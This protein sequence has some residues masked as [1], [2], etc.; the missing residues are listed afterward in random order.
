MQIT[1]RDAFQKAFAHEGAGRRAAARAIY[2]EILAALPG[3]PGALLKLADQ[4]IDGGMLD[5]AR[6]RL[7]AAIAGA[8]T[9]QLPAADIWFAYARL[10][11]KQGDRNAAREAC[12]RALEIAPDALGPLR[13]LA[14]LMLQEGDP[15]SAQALCRRA[16]QREPRDVESLHLLGKALKAMGAF[17]AARSVLIDCASIAGD[18]PEVLTTL[19][20]VCLDAGDAAEA[21]E[22]LE[23]AIAAGAQ[24]AGVWD[25]LGLAYRTRGDHEGALSAFERAVAADPELTPALA[26]LVHARRYL[27]EW[28]GLAKHEQRLIA[29]LDVPGSDPRWS[30]HIALNCS[31]TPAQELA[32][33]RRWSRAV[34]PTPATPR[35]AKPR[36]RRLRVGYLSSDFREH[37]TGRLMAGLFEQCDRSRLEIFA[38]SYG[39]DDGSELRS[40][41]RASFGSA[42]RDVQGASDAEAA[43][44]ICD[45]GLDVLIDRKGHTHGGRLAILASRPAPVQLHYMSFPGTL[46]YDAVD[47]LIAD[48]VVVPVGAEVDY[49]E[50]VWRMPRCYFVNDGH[51]ALP[52]SATRA[53]V[54][55]PEKVV[56][57]A[58]LNQS[59]KLS[60]PV[61]AA[62][63][64]GLRQAP[65][66]VLWLLAAGARAHANLRAH[67]AQAGVD[68]GRMLFA[69]PLAQDAHIARLRCAD[70]AL[71]TRPV[72]SHTT[73]CD[74]LWAGVPMLTCPGRTFAS[75]V[76]AS[77]LRA[78]GLPELIAASLDDY[79]ARLVE[80]ASAPDALRDYRAFL[81]RTRQHN[82]LFDT[83][84]FA[85]DWEALLERAYEGTLA[86]R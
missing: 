37:P 61:F 45:D 44:I 39:P 3:H 19:G 18:D 8:A 86:A 30:P 21:R 79:Q 77:V 81:E 10:H 38:Y 9:Q 62:W 27:C 56:V 23:Q 14:W 70:L 16:L 40:R 75:R 68:P 12:E 13:L 7:D 51:R 15:R 43:R 22:R 71:D 34:L 74:A 72:G 33:A 46:G 52:P 42:W 4:D 25:N 36:G 49:H 67:A 85:R 69:P 55:L 28:D 26:N 58:C 76:G 24:S 73:G 66:A 59:Y 2:V 50:R 47:G 83:V 80:L 84:G 1:V 65:N 20:A 32:V 63:M 82:P 60:P 53:E 78:A 64:E 31:L 6:E 54:G 48:D 57:L 29:T 41:I 35:P 17:A 5:A 11:L